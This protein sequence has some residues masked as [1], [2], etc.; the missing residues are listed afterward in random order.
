MDPLTLLQKLIGIKPLSLPS[1]VC[2]HHAGELG[3]LCGE[4]TEE[5]GSE[6]VSQQPQTHINPCNVPVICI[7]YLEVCLTNNVFTV[8]HDLVGTSVIF[9]EYPE[10][11]MSVW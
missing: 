3:S 1:F 5:A 10:G 4:E 11:T 7:K 6:N 8:L 2:I 9:I